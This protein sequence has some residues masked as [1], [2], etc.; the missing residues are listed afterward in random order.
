[1]IERGSGHVSIRDIS[2]RADVNL[3]QIY[4]YFGSK[5]AL[6][7]AVLFE[8]IAEFDPTRRAGEVEGEAGAGLAA[9]G[10]EPE[11]LE[12][13]IGATHERL[14]AA[15]ILPKL[16]LRELARGGPELR[17]LAERLL[18]PRLRRLESLVRQGQRAGSLRRGPP[19]VQAALCAG[20]FL[21]WHLFRP[22][23]ATYGVDVLKPSTRRA[24]RAETIETL[25]CGIFRARRRG[26][27]R[28][29]HP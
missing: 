27:A 25:R 12:S 4:Y 11:A 26:R 29:T 15:S 28:R 16:M 14:A 6:R 8:A 5:E 17:K 20:L 21:Y 2:R 22:V 9:A 23:L 3:S 19:R 7:A 24:I 10:G 1:M 13:I 18:L